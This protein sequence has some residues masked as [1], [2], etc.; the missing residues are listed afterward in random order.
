MDGALL[1]PTAHMDGVLPVLTKA[2]VVGGLQLTAAGVLPG[3]KDG[4]LAQEMDGDHLKEEEDLVDRGV[5]EAGEA[6]G[7]PEV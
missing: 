5:A 3:P 6:Q 4:D 2:Q 1:D 7:I